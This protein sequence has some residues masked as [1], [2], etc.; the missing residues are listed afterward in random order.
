MEIS[1]R[2]FLKLLGVTTAGAA[3]GAFGAST[4]ISVPDR[5]FE[6]AMN[7]P[8]IETWKNSICSLCPGGCGIR[9]RLIDD[10]PVRVLGN[11][12]YPINRGAVCPLAEAA[13]EEL[14]HPKRLRQPM[15]RTGQRGQNQWEPVSWDEAIGMIT[16]RLKA[17]R[18]QN[19]AHKL[20]IVTRD[21]SE[22]IV[23]FLQRFMSAFGSPN[24]ICYSEMSALNLPAFLTHG[25]QG[26]PAYD[27]SH[28]DVVLNF[29]GDILDEGPSP[30]RYNQIYADL[31]NRPGGARARIIHFSAYMSRTAANANEW[32]P[33]K[34]GTAAILAL[35]IAYVMIKDRSYDKEFIR[36][37]AFGF[38]EWRDA[39]GKIHKGF[40]QLVS[41]RYYPE[42][43]SEITGVPAQ[44][45]IEIAR[46]FAASEAAIAIAGSQATTS[47][48]SLYTAWAIYCLNALKG[49][50]EKRG[51][52]YFP[53]E[54]LRPALPKIQHDTAAKAGLA[55]QKIGVD[56]VLGN[57]MAPDS[58]DSLLAALQDDSQDTPDTVIF[59]RA[60]P[61]FESTRRKQYEAALQ[62]VPFIVSCAPFLD[63]TAAHAD[64][65][66]PEHVFLEKWEAS[67]NVPTTAFLHFGLQQPVIQP[68]YDTRHFGDVLLQ[69]GQHLGGKITT[70]LSWESY[71]GFLQ[72]HA[73]AI[74]ESGEGTIVSES[75][76][77]AFIEFL[78]KRGWQPFEY[79]TFEEFWQVLLEKG[80]WW[81]PTYPQG[82]HTRIFKNKSRKFEFYSQ[83]MA[84][85]F[86]RLLSAD[87]EGAEAL[88]RQL[89]IEARDDMVFLPHY[90][91]PRFSHNTADFP[92]HFLTFQQLVN[93]G[94]RGAH[95]PLVQ[96]LNGLH[97][98]EY[99]NSWAELNPETAARLGLHEDDA[100][101]IISPK[102][103]LTAKVKIVPTV[104]PEVVMMPFGLG[105][106]PLAAGEEK[107]GID[108][109]EIL[110][111]DADSMSGLP[112]R[113]S[114]KVRIEKAQKQDLA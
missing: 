94:G 9:V 4:V 99:Y 60:N 113:M 38:S 96:E 31:R 1:R 93:P 3:V 8:R 81:D 66:L 78:K 32:I 19:E 100:I 59:Y 13:T 43:A 35:S 44:K 69:L 40:E 106:R 61:L 107:I 16:D 36:K 53:K 21:N 87:K 30:V 45:I 74:Y 52:L 54:M 14:F 90:E 85:R 111:D 2:E 58:V 7:G 27:L 25:W 73:K 72:E 22:L 26:S 56:S 79:S 24:L 51:G 62:D 46:E 97:S 20:A 114:T 112:S 92:Y 70:A 37:N 71:T 15:R 101:H 68:L 102:G 86:K 89:K 50:F 105:R 33:V 41:E 17:L 10:I 84:T 65:V 48:N 12:L 39:T 18:E 57:G 64:I 49:N 28:A 77:P 34:P 108:P 6:R 80:G 42:K 98:R 29:G 55:Q 110:V 23:E 82:G 83:V 76:E 88:F 91:T 95:L 5:V 67:V 11:P 109:Y 47:T 75:K 103:R 63:E 104:M